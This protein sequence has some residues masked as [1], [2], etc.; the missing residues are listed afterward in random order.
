MEEEYRY[1]AILID[2]ILSGGVSEMRVYTNVGS[3]FY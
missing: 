1:L 3:V 2:L